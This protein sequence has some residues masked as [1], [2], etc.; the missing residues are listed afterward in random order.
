VRP[1]L[2]R[3]FLVLAAALAAPATAAAE[4]PRVGVVVATRVNVTDG[5]GDRL[6]LQL[7]D[8][9]R[10]DL[11]V[12]VISGAEARRRLPPGGLP[13]DCVARKRCV[14][15]VAER[16]DADQLLFLVIVRIGPRL[17]IDSTWVDR[18]GGAAASRPA[19]VIEDG[20]D[21]AAVVF[22]E[23][24]LRLLPEAS[25][26]A[27][28]TPVVT[29]ATSVE[30]T[31]APRGRRVTTPV[32]VAG[33]VAGIALIGGVG[34]ALSAKGDY[35]EMEEQGCDRVTCPD[36]E[37]RVD[38]MENKALAADVLFGAAAA[39]ALNGTIVSLV[40]AAEPES[41]PVAVGAN[42]GGGT[43]SFRARF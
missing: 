35:D 1:E 28:A 31:T 18:S 27:A 5:E 38:R 8:A 43:V 33:A 23:A 32:I 41:A 26:R 21:P 37:D 9:L 19:L 6:S 40:S 2:L 29:P 16:L 15:D 12:D 20:G 11:Q 10:A 24:T 25:P 36:A 4:A 3:S 13:E 34:F 17:Q 14:R 7:A 22:A 30:V 39:A 42:D